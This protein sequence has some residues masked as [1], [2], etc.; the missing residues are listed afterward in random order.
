[1]P[2]TISATPIMVMNTDAYCISGSRMVAS[3]MDSDCPRVPML[4]ERRMAICW[5]LTAFASSRSPATAPVP[6]R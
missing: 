5:S 1:M 4:S 3:L 6:H 2:N